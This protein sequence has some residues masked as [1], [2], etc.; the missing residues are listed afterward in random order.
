LPTTPGIYQTSIVLTADDGTTKETSRFA[1]F[2]NTV[3]PVPTPIPMPPPRRRW[4]VLTDTD[5][6]TW[7]LTWSHDASTTHVLRLER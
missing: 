1:F 5:G 6:A 2:V 4:I 7:S 3:P